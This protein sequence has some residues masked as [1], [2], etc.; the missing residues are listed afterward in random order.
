MT[1]QET[2]GF[3]T[4]WTASGFVSGAVVGFCSGSGLILFGWMVG[5]VWGIFRKITL[6]A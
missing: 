3:I 6:S 2:L 4:A 1:A 5:Q